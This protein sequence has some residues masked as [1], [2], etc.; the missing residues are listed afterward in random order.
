MRSAATIKLM[1]A[2]P[3]LATSSNLFSLQS[4]QTPDQPHIQAQTLELLDPS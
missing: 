4:D 2:F 3:L 1:H